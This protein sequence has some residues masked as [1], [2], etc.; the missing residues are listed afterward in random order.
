MSILSE[1]TQPWCFD[2]LIN[3]LI[4]KNNFNELND[5]IQEIINK[6]TINNID[7][8][9][10]TKIYLS[11][12][13]FRKN[14]QKKFDRQ[15]NIY[16]QN[17][18]HIMNVL[19]K[20][21][22]LNENSTFIWL[23]NIINMDKSIEYNNPCNITDEFIG[24]FRFDLEDLIQNNLF[25][26]KS[27]LKHFIFDEWSFVIQNNAHKLSQKYNNKK[28]E[29]IIDEND[30]IQFKRPGITSNN[31]NRN[32]K[33]S[34]G[35][36]NI[37]GNKRKIM[38]NNN[39]NNNINKNRLKR[40]KLNNAKKA[41]ERTKAIMRDRNRSRNKNRRTGSVIMSL[42]ER[43]KNT[44]INIKTTKKAPKKTKK[45]K[46]DKLELIVTDNANLPTND[47]SQLNDFENWLELDNPNATTNNDNNNN[48]N[49]MNSINE[50]ISN[51]ANNM[52]FGLPAPL[53]I[54]PSIPKPLDSI[55]KPLESIPKPLS[56]NE[57]GSN[58]ESHNTN[59][60]PPPLFVP[61]KTVPPPPLQTKPPP[62]LLQPPSLPELPQI[63]SSTETMEQKL[64]NMG[65]PKALQ[66]Y[67]WLYAN[68]N[69]LT[70]DNRLKIIKYLTG[71]YRDMNRE[72]E[73]IILNRI[74]LQNGKSKDSVIWLLHK[75]GTWKKVTI[76]RRI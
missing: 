70:N 26:K 59:N 61:S 68:S 63:Q 36:T 62:P 21:N 29:W 51:N 43:Q 52:D 2:S 15:I 73:E 10:L 25:N 37:I 64:T 33:M 5:Y 28:H 55:P 16:K 7:G 30:L 18:I 6:N 14:N 39:S 74:P 47:S 8:I 46:K 41:M 19:D 38:N 44:K 34:P 13:F 27:E 23:K 57:S 40:R 50:S 20:N 69:A 65:I 42:S 60:N 35:N 11:I 32:N 45:S 56:E 17:C 58:T 66:R 12:L 67:K 4:L 72:K 48:N 9:I 71:K 53:E 76:Q 3:D 22:N 24:E 31:N 1:A 54:L 75:Q 49:E